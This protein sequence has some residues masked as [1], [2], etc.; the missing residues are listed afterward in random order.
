VLSFNKLFLISSSLKNLLW[1][2]ENG[3]SYLMD[4]ETLF[5]TL[6][7]LVKNVLKFFKS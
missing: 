4:F 6:F 2:L 3:L 5:K 7:C 1:F